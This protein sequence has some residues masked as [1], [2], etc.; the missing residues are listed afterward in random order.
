MMLGLDLTVDFESRYGVTYLA[1]LRDGEDFTGRAKRAA[2][3]IADEQDERDEDLFLAHGGLEKVRSRLNAKWNDEARS[4]LDL[5]RAE[6]RLMVMT[7]LEDARLAPMSVV[8]IS[9]LVGYGVVADRRIRENDVIGEYTGVLRRTRPG[10]EMNRYLAGT[11][12]YGRFIDFIIDGQDEGNIT[13]FINHSFKSPNVRSEHVFHDL[14]WHRVLR[15][16]RDILPGEQILWNYGLDYWRERE[17]PA[18][19]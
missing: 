6:E 9:D 12:P 19:L 11:Q 10:D 2:R 1:Y 18:E 8:R 4:L 15:A 14:R 3:E 17:I 5:T 7:A 13:R 16:E